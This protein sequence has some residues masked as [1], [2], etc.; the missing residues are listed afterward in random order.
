MN[1]TIIGTGFVGVVTAAVHASFGHTVTGL[2]IDE[3]KISALKKN[4]VPFFEPGLNE[5]L[6]NQQQAGK[7]SFTTD[8]RSAIS[9]A[10]IIFI[11]VG[12]PSAPDGQADLR[13]VLASTQALAPYL[14]KDAIVVIKSTV[15][16]GT[17][18]KIEALIGQHTKVKFHTAS[19]PE[20]LKEGSTVE[21][22]LH[23]DRVVIGAT[24]QVV[25]DKLEELHRPLQAP[26]VRVKPESAQMAKYAANAYLATRITFINQIADLCEKNGADVEEVVAAISPD[27]RI[28]EHYWYPGFGYGGSCFPKD[29]KELA[30]YSRAIGESDNLFN[31]VNDLNEDRIPKLLEQFENLI[32]GWSDKQVAVLGL[33]FKPNTDDMREAPATLVIPILLSRGAVVKSFDPMANW[34]KFF[35]VS[36]LDKQHRQVDSIKQA[37]KGADVIISLIEWPQIIGFDFASTKENKEQWFIDARNQFSAPILK[38]AGYHFRGLGRP[39]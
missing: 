36:K 26:I 38:K 35:K 6:K 11:A 20:F 4:Q 5:L 25:F 39:A 29:V 16:P 7:L 12:T 33:S 10:E 19:V 8:Y 2:D 3:Q 18:E 23:P 1:I 31:K 17:L 9:T 37:V 27:Q 21:D 14:K 28:G 24:N 30:A 32:G 22:T 34:Q 15:P 13:F